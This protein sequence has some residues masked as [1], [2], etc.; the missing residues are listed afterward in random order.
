MYIYIYSY[1]Q[2]PANVVRGTAQR[3]HSQQFRSETRE[4]ELQEVREKELRGLYFD[5]RQDKTKVREEMANGK[6]RIMTST[7]E[8]IVLVAQPGDAYLGHVTPPTHGAESQANTILDFLD[9]A[10]VVT[11]HLCCVGCD[12]CITNTGCWGGAIRLLEEALGRALQWHICLLHA[13]ELPLRHVMET[14]DG[15]TGGP[16]TWSGPI[17]QQLKNCLQL[18]VVKFQPIALELPDPELDSAIL[19]TDQRYSLDIARAISTGKC[20]PTL[21]ARD[22]G[23]VNHSRW[24]TTANRVMRVYIGTKRPSA[25]LKHIVTIIMKLY[26][27][28]WFAV[29]MRW[30][31]WEGPKH[32]ARMVTLTR[33][34]PKKYRDVLQKYIQN[35]AFFAHPENVLVAMVKDDRAEVRRLGVQ[36]VLQARRLHADD[37]EVRR[38]TVP[39]LNFSATDYVDIVD[40][41]CVPVTPPPL[42]AHISSEQL[43]EMLLLPETPSI[44]IPA[45]PCHSPAVERAVKMVTEAAAQ[46]STP[47]ARDGNIRQK[48]ASRKL[49]PEFQSKQDYHLTK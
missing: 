5:G 6:V 32:L 7:E 3:G 9:D 24:G 13:N 36:R 39:D 4:K 38:F 17:G 28:M 27:P 42:L 35:N 19:S 37:D 18:P 1:P 29:K 47:D 45:F 10:K 12:G 25:A 2:L 23:I 40:W 30:Q 21:A 41:E 31:C 22:P 20:P 8:H 43:E 16:N 44:D 15:A 26:V 48:I 11:T 34:F 14:F 46:V 33:Q 49:M